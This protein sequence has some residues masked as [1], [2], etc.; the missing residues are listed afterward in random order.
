MPRWPPSAGSGATARLA[1]VLRGESVESV[2][3][4]AVAVVAAGGRPVAS[5][6]DPLR[7]AVVRSAVKPFQA[8]PLLLAGGIGRFDL[9][10][11]DLALIC[12][13]HGGSPAHV[14]R[15]AALLARGGFDAGALA[16]GAH[17]PFDPAAAAALER[18]G[19]EPTALHNNCSG[20]H[21]G[22][23]LACRALGLDPAGYLEPDHPLQ[24]RIA[25]EL[26]LACGVEAEAL[27]RSIDGC[28]APTWELPLA[29]LARGWGALAAPE[30]CGLDA[31][32]SAALGRLAAAMGARPDQVA[33]AGRFTTALG[34]ATAGRVIGKEGA[35]GVYAIAVRGPVAL[36]IA[37]K[38]ADGA[39][40]ARD[41]VVLELLRQLGSISGEQMRGL[42]PFD[43]P[44][45]RNHRGIE[46]GAIVAELE[47]AEVPD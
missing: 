45:L 32:R 21:A 2:H 31:G 37:L 25:G 22:M 28:S 41:V 40:R 4:G 47:L 1:A 7:P 16:C 29:A 30:A 38:I 44:R 11:A 42:A 36:G 35:E 17:R 6:G 20:K 13:S 34:A 43:R 5:C 46:V 27:R 18:D 24:R 14:E 9:D 19:R 26:A 15:A 12:S 10:D 33:G 39:E 8:L 23:L 3:C